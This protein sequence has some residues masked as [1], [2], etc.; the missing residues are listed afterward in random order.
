[1]ALPPPETCTIGDVTLAYRTYGTGFPLVLINGLASA[2]DTWNPPVL[3]ALAR[4]FRVIVFD[5]RGTGYSGASAESFSIP[6]FSRDTAGLMEHLGITRAHVL[7][8][9]MG[10]CI[11]QELELAFPE[12]V[13]RLV[14][15]SGDCGGTE[16]VRTDPDVFARLIDRSGTI[17]D[18]VNRMLPLLFPSFWLATHDPF[19]YCPAVEEITSD[20]NAARQLA[21]F[22]SWPGTFSRL[23][24]IRSRTLVITGDADAVVPCENSR[25]LAGKIPGAKLVE[26]PG[27]GHGLMY[28]CPDRFGE[29]VL[30]F[31]Y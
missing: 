10:T 7:G 18:V 24:N 28:Q 14:L 21:A 27:A 13:D 1:M 12:K 3:D 9:S 6:L 22:L 8:F 19:R 25:L 26:F 5:H 30:D 4:H 31:L 15:V 20:E 23:E 2:M 17:D 11:A 16:A 29:T